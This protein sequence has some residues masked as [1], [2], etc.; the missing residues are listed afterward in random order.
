MMEEDSCPVLQSSSFWKIQGW[1]KV[2]LWSSLSK[3]PLLQQEISLAE[4]PLKT[5]KAFLKILKTLDGNRWKSTLLSN[6]FKCT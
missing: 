2:H 1:Y 3:G 5:L 6:Y 4:T